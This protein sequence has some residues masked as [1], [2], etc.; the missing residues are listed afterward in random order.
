MQDGQN[1]FVPPKELIS[2]VDFAN[3]FAGTPEPEFRSWL[4]A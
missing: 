3:P 4:A 1:T 2:V